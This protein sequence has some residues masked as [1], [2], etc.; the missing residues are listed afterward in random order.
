LILLK[1]TSSPAETPP[2][3][4]LSSTSE[5]YTARLS[6]S[7]FTASFDSSPRVLSWRKSPR[8]VLQCDPR[9]GARGAC[10][11]YRATS[12]SPYN[13]HPPSRK[14]FII[15]LYVSFWYNGAQTSVIS[16]S[17]NSHFY[18]KK[19][20]PWY[21]FRRAGQ[22]SLL[23]RTRKTIYSVRGKYLFRH[24]CGRCLNGRFR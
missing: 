7:P 21:S 9:E 13:R 14:L 23:L 12:S 16:S 22:H 18:Q 6:R 3:I 4:M 15:S 19:K 17:W 20:N 10:R 5:R 8:C 2:P 11:G 1:R 24:F